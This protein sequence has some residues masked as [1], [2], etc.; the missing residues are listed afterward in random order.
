MVID[1]HAKGQIYKEAPDLLT[2]KRSNEVNIDQDVF[3]QL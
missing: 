3:Q 2:Y 1:T